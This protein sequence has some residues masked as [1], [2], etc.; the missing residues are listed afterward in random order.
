MDGLRP[1]HRR[2]R[3][4]IPRWFLLALSLVFRRSSAADRAA[5][6]SRS[7]RSASVFASCASFASVFACSASLVARAVLP[8]LVLNRLPKHFI[9]NSEDEVV[10]E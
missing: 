6:A 5:S 4:P 9:L 2:N 1:N 10:K 3:A 8:L 7:L